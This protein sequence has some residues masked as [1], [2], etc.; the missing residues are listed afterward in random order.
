MKRVSIGFLYN[1]ATQAVLLQKRDL[2]TKAN[3]GRWGLWGGAA[4]SNESPIKCF[5]RE[6]YEELALHLSEA[7]PILLMND[8]ED[9][10]DRSVFYV[11][12]YVEKTSL[13]LGEGADFDWLEHHRV[14]SMDLTPSAQKYL[15][16]F[17]DTIE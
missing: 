13:I 12:R 9:G 11:P 1:P 7:E 8:Q 17:Y 15:Q 3:P 6:I 14:F 16:Y 2:K 10:K 5:V 4:E